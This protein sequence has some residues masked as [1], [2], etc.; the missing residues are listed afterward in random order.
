MGTVQILDL[1][2]DAAADEPTAPVLRTP[3]LACTLPSAG[4][5]GGDAARLLDEA[6]V[7]WAATQGA[8]APEP[9]GSVPPCAGLPP[10][11]SVQLPAGGWAVGLRTPATASRT[12]DLAAVPMGP[13]QRWW[14]VLPGEG[15][16]GAVVFEHADGPPTRILASSGAAEPPPGLVVQVEHGGI[17]VVDLSGP[18][19]Y[20]AVRPEAGAGMVGVGQRLLVIGHQP[21]TLDGVIREGEADPRSLRVVVGAP[22][23]PTAGD[24]VVP[25][26]GKR[27]FR[28]DAPVVD[29]W[30]GR[31][32]IVGVAL[33]GNKL[34]L[35]GGEP[36]HAEIAL[37]APDGTVWVLPVAVG[38]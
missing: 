25:S 24:L 19:V 37:Q 32:E 2:G 10:I 23:K 8:V 14:H 6:L 5:P 27:T 35:T 1:T 9:A 12:A 20:A 36:G 29:A 3:E 15:D 38:R 7:T 26:G 11:E 17:T 16:A 21:G 13:D 18:P 33:D 30:S 22:P 4:A 34:R 28:P 31:P